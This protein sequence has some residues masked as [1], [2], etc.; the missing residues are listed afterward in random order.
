VVEELDG[1]RI[2]V[3]ELRLL[4]NETAAEIDALLP[5]VLSKAFAGELR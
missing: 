4:Q 1:L 3:D 5:S 2:K